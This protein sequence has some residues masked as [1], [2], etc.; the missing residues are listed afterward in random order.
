MTNAA[1]TSSLGFASMASVGAAM[2]L[3]HA[4][5]PVAE[6]A[7]AGAIEASL[8]LADTAPM[9]EVLQARPQ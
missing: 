9:P 3:V 2:N 1:T 7:V 6:S 5:A 4:L 8:V